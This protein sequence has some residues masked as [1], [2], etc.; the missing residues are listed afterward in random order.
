MRGRRLRPPR[1][2]RA[3]RRSG[4]ARP[5][6][7]AAR[8]ARGRPRASAR[9]HVDGRVHLADRQLLRGGVGRLDDSGQPPVPSPQRRARTQRGSAGSKD[10]TV[11]AASG[12]RCSATRSSSRL[13]RQQGRIAREDEQVA[14]E[15]PRAPAGRRRPRRPF[16]SGRSCTTTLTPV[17]QRPLELLARLGRNRRRRTATARAAAPRAAPSRASGGRAASCRCFGRLDFM[18]VPRPAAMTTAASGR[19]FT[20][21]PVMAGAGGFEPPVTGPKPVA[22]PLG[23]APAI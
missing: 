2:G 3:R 12:R 21:P 4:R 14:V 8:D 23:Y 15:C 18:R 16:P 11:T 10:S 22:L 7:S 1:R 19:S 20:A 6:R 17:G 9:E 5:A 13:R